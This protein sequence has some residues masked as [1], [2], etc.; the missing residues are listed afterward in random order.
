MTKMIKVL[1]CVVCFSGSV[2]AQ[3][4]MRKLPSIINHPSLN[5]YAPYMS[6]DGNAIAFISN[7]GQDGA[8]TISYTSREQD[9]TPPVELPKHLNN[10]LNFMRGYALNA[11][12]KKI[13]VTSAKTPVVGGY[14]IFVSELKGSTW[15]QPE[16]LMLPINTKSNEACPSLTPD[17]KAI[18][19]MRCDKMDAMEASG[20]KIFRALKKSNGQWE[21]PV[22]LPANINT[23]NSQTPRILADGVTLLFSSDKFPGGK[24][25]MD[26]YMTRLEGN[27]WSDPVPLNF[28]NSEVDDQYVS[29]NA[30]GRYL[31]REAKSP[32]GNYELT[33]FLFPADLRPKSLMKLEGNVKID[34][35]VSS[36][37]Y[38][39]ITDVQSKKR[40]YNTQLRGD[41]SF[42]AYLPEGSRYEVAVDPEHANLTYFAR[43]F[44]LQTQVPQKEKV[45]ALIKQVAPGD[46]YLLDLV[47]FA[48]Y[49]SKLEPTSEPELK[50]LARMIKANPTKQFQVE[51]GLIGYKEDSLQTSPDFTQIRVDTLTAP[52]PATPAVGNVN[53]ESDTAQEE[54]AQEYYGR[55]V[56]VTYHNDR[57]AEQ[58]GAI[59]K[60]LAA[61]GV[62]AQ[63]V[64]F[65]VKALPGEEPQSKV[66]VKVVVS[67]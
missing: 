19:F 64:T 11:D 4:P 60:V 13:Y 33:E 45:S 10:R 34:A 38:V 62:T 25:K 39:S 37:A 56:K 47:S 51:V 26:L 63:Q 36:S 54:L 18:Y 48:P 22:E 7:S 27:T 52:L 57:T 31:L 50:R 53:I 5:L 23:G 61:E 29:V 15:T 46:E 28:T 41:G 6:A 65:V 42:T 35:G 21:E 59:E 16:N 3:S 30:L 8:Y 44:D 43:V 67:K 32:R 55:R 1:L 17:E 20:C 9:W 58:A 2:V 12:G 24:G 40:I 49:S 66:E 14:D